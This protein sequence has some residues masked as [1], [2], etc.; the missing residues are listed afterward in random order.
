MASTA[1]APPPDQR[2]P[3]CLRRAPPHDIA[4]RLHRPAA[5]HHTLA[6]V[7]RIVH[8]VAIVGEVAALP[9]ERFRLLCGGG[10]HPFAGPQQRCW[11]ARGEPAALLLSPALAPHA[12]GAVAGLGQGVDVLGG[13]LEVQDFS[14]AG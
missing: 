14:A 12:L 7:V 13:V 4:A 5:D 10:L 6:A 3:L 9:P 11:S 1:S 8:A 2:M